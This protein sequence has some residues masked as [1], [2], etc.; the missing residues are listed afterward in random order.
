MKPRFLFLAVA[1]MSAT[2]IF[3]QDVFTASNAKVVFFSKT[4]VE[5]IEGTTNVAGTVINVKTKQILFK[6]QNTSFQFKEKLMQEHFNENYMESDKFPVSD[7]NG[8]IIGKDDISKVGAYNVTIVGILNVH[9]KK[10]EY[11]VAGK[12]V[13]KGDNF[14]FNTDFKVKLADHGVEVPTVVFAKI[15]E[16]L[17]VKVVAN[18]K[19]YKKA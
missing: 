17:D 18:C 9:G 4:P 8:K 16:V 2:S 14:T 15:A 19:L 6:I 5:N 11:K 10:K 3:S 1:L 13:N 12:L 7:F